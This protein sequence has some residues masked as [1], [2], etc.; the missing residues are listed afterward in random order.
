MK[1][2]SMTNPPSLNPSFNF[3]RL[4]SSFSKSYMTTIWIYQLVLF[5]WRVLV[6]TAMEFLA[7][8]KEFLQLFEVS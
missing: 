6:F 3:G 7:Y 5:D 1:C 8:F 4:N 2:Y